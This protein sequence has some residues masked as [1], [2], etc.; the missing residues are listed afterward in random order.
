MSQDRTRRRFVRAIGGIGL[1]TMAG[2]LGGDEGSGSG[3]TTESGEMTDSEMTTEATETTD[4][5]GMDAGPAAIT[6]RIENVAATDFY[7][8]DTHTGGQI[9]ITPGAYAV[10]PGGNPMFTEGE[11][12][13][14]GLEALA[15][16]GPPTG[17]P[18]E[19]GLVAELR[20]DDAAA[21]AGAYT[22]ADTV[23][24]P[25][26][27][28]GEVP[29]APPIAPGGAFEFTVEAEPGAR[30]SVASMFVPSNDVFLAP[31]APGIELWPMDGDPVSGDVTDAV[32]LWDAGTEPNAQPPGEGPDQAPAQNSLDQGD[33][34]DGVVRPLSSVDDGYRYP[35]VND[36][37]GI[38]L[39]PEGSM[40]GSDGGSMTDTQS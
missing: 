34:E 12:A 8:D 11:P 3:T 33:D 18:D 36:L 38:T 19:P 10:H 40:E 16:A 1:G 15:E 7:G 22:P 23:A 20:S 5:G 24:D 21:T 37:V 29:G 31:G 26:D 4:S 9:W 2:C 27:P 6:V 28:M 25:N 13:S 35:A 30:L 14:V 32:E 39:T 17:F